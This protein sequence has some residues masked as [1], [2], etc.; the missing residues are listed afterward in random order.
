[1]ADWIYA[2]KA[3]HSVDG[4][5]CIMHQV[6]RVS[7]PADLLDRAGVDYIVKVDAQNDNV[8]SNRKGTW[9]LGHDMWSL[10][11][12]HASQIPGPNGTGSFDPNAQPYELT[13]AQGRAVADFIEILGVIGEEFVG[14]GYLR[15]YGWQTSGNHISE[16]EKGVAERLKER[17]APYFKCQYGAF[18][19]FWHTVKFGFRFNGSPL[20]PVDSYYKSRLQSKSAARN[21]C[22]FFVHNLDGIGMVHDIK[23]YAEDFQSRRCFFQVVYAARV[24]V[25]GT[26]ESNG[27]V[28]NR[29][30]FHFWSKVEQLNDHLSWS[31]HNGFRY[32]R[33]IDAAGGR[34]VSTEHP[35][36]DHEMLLACCLFVYAEGVVNGVG[37]CDVWCWENSEIFGTDMNYMTEPNPNPGPSRA[38]YVAWLP[39]ASQPTPWDQSGNIKGGPESPMGYMSIGA[40]AKLMYNTT[41]NTE[42][43]SWSDCKYKCIERQV[44]GNAWSAVNENWVEVQSDNTTI[45]EWANMYDGVNS[46]TTGPGVVR[47]GLAARVRSK[48]VG[49]TEH[50]SLMW[51]HAGRGP[52]VK[53]KYIFQLANGRLITQVVQGGIVEVFNE[54]FSTTL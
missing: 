8:P 26:V 53:E 19:T 7:S 6:F 41:V 44:D 38:N 23:F 25:Y 13:K 21:S 20:S 28:K 48:T 37:I 31:I 24:C 33:R 17:G 47:G 36:M 29:V 45:L 35:Q 15:E 51:Y 52:N 1:M 18:Y 3:T 54:S 11:V 16:F 2:A 42:G 50:V 4:V 34:V 46:Q 30:C 5:K 39:D 49:N 32:I 14:E 43:V 40:K 12:N 9:V 27:N 22:E 10:L